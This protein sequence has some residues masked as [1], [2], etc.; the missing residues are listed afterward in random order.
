MNIDSGINGLEKLATIN[1]WK[2]DKALNVWPSEYCN[3]I[4]GT[5]GEIFPPT[6]AQ[7]TASEPEEKL[8]IFDGN[9]CR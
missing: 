1:T 6:T 5:E 2:G 9:L 3:M 7:T 4:N 8:Y